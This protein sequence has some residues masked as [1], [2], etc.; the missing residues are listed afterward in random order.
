MK[1]LKLF[2]EFDGFVE[3][4]YILGHDDIMVNIF[5]GQITDIYTYTDREHH[6][7]VGEWEIGQNKVFQH[8]KRKYWSEMLEELLDSEDS[9]LVP[10]MD[11][12]GD[13]DVEYNKFQEEMEELIRTQIPILSATGKYNI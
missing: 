2:E 3:I 6:N 8:L 11:D 13:E 12:E 10:L 5:K 9:Y 1:Y 7:I 4:T